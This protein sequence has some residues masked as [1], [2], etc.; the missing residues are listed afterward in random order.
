[1]HVLSSHLPF[2]L[3]SSSTSAAGACELHHQ[4]GAFVHLLHN[5]A[6]NTEQHSCACRL[7]LNGAEDL[8]MGMSLELIRVKA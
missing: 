8:P 2:G 3:C 4:L 6:R 5:S 1:M 7:R